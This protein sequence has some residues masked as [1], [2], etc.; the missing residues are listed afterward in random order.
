MKKK[1]IILYDLAEKSNNER[2]RILQK[3][4]SHRD[5]SNYDYSYQRKGLLEKVQ[6]E[7]KKKT[8]LYLQTKD[9]LARIS[10]ILKKLKVSFD[11]VEN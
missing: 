9:D 11:V 10:E 4:Y 8:A 5:K 2:T 6:Y 3:L 1:T 7:K